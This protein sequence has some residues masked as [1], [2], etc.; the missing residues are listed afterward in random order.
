MRR[1]LR[2]ATATT[3]LLAGCHDLGNS[4]ALPSGV[5]DP[6]TYN[7]EAGALAFADGTRTLFKFALSR[8]L[9]NASQLTDEVTLVG[10]SRGGA[11]PD[12]DRR[13]D[14]ELEDLYGKLAQARGQA[15]LTRG[16]LQRYGST[17][18]PWHLAE[19]YAI[20]GYTELLLADLYC[21]GIPLSTVD[22]D[23][24]FTPAPGSS[25]GEVYR[26]AAVLFDTAAS[27]AGGNDS[28]ATFARVGWGRALLAMGLPDSA[29]RVVSLIDDISHY[30]IRVHVGRHDNGTASAEFLGGS[31]SDREGGTG[32]PYLSSLD[33]RTWGFPVQACASPINC[34]QLIIPEKYRSVVSNDSGPVAVA[35]GVEARLIEAEADLRSGGTQWLLILNRLRT[36]GTFTTATR[37]D[38]PGVSPGPAGYED[39]TWGPGTGIGMIAPSVLARTTPRCEQGDGVNPPPPCSDT[40]W[41]RGLAPLTDP[42]ASLSGQAA[43]DARVDLLFRE[44]AFWLFITGHRQGDL[45]RLIRQYGRLPNSVYPTGSYGNGLEY[46]STV[47]LTVPEQSNPLYEGC[48]NHGA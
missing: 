29:A 45:R 27:L 26:Q 21:S 22:Y 32:L 7:T 16:A 41:Y 48:I 5:Q 33:P 15:H 10:A 1:N 14:V 35:S 9:E 4:P 25:T 8:Y 43:I 37:S 28:V 39:T 31:E 23:G 20:E 13:A 46:G 2:W 24:D 42:G 11:I 34:W 6:A 40:V 12:L 47:V 30:V 17:L 18:P 36:D 19:M 44:R 38:I 3:V